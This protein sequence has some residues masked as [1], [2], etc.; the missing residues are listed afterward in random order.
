MPAEAIQILVVEDD[1][2]FSALL[3]EELGTRGH[4][5]VAA[6][7][8]AEARNA[9]QDTGFDVVLLDLHLPDG[10]G[11]VLLREIASEG[12]ATES[13][14]LTGHAELPSAIEAMKLGAYDYLSKP[15]RLDELHALVE[16]AAEKARLRR[17]N[18]ALRVR[19][20]RHETVRGLITADPGMTRMLASLDRV[21]GS[22]LP[23]L[24]QGESGTGKELVARAVHAKSPR[25]AF[26]FIPINCAALPE[27]IIES[28]LFGHERGAF[29]GAVDRKTGLFEVASR[30][31][32]FLDEIGDLGI[33][34][35]AKLLRVIESKEFFRVGGTKVVRVDVRIVSATNRD[36][37][38]EVE[39][40]RFREDLFYRLNGVSVALPPLR[41]R[42]GDIP[43]LARH[44][45]DRIGGGKMVAAAAMEVL[46]AYHWP[47]NVRELEMVVQR[48][49]LLAPEAVIGAED[50]PLDIRP[51]ATPRVLR[52]DLT[53]EEIEKEYVKAVLERNHGHRRR[54]AQILGIDP[55]TLYNKLRSWG[56]A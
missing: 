10:S 29:T 16:K 40:G 26:P 23:V 52:T 49:A 53:L 15:A 51:R 34:L 4:A 39:S 56:E 6:A 48:A 38:A 31:V 43:L 17:D 55:K 32:V 44:F 46:Q 35:Q 24:I 47:G 54:A 7:S 25:S 9:L 18:A 12:L 50:L 5:V 19:L 20:Q 30:G 41:E 36:L 42:R 11:L 3:R 2:P 22:D 14:V 1:V 13:V 8:L 28:E 37:R 45:L 21:A 33:A 27:A